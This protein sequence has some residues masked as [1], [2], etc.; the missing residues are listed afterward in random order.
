M[1]ASH[2]SQ[3][4]EHG[5]EPDI[6]KIPISRRRVVQ[7]LACSGAAL[8]L[9][10]R[11]MG[12]ATVLAADPAKK[13]GMIT[14]VTRAQNLET[15]VGELWNW[16]IPNDRFF[17]RSHFGPPPV[18][19]LKD[20]RVQVGG[21]VRRPLRLTLADLKGF[22]KATLPAVLQCSGN[23]RSFFSPSV[24]GT[25]WEKGA[26][27]N[28]WWTGVRLADVLEQAG[29]G[30]KAGHVQL[31]GADRPALPSVPLFVRSIPIDKAMHA[32]TLLAYE[33]NGEP[34]PL[35]HGAPV[36]L[37][38]PGWAGDAWVKWLAHLNV[39]EQ[40]AEGYYMQTAYRMPVKPIR[41]G[42]TVKP[43]ETTPVTDLLV[44]S[45]ITHPV[46]GSVLPVGD[47]LI[48]GVAFT[49]EGEVVRVEVS[50][51]AGGRWQEA[52]LVGERAAYAW[53]LWRYVWTGVQA[54]S[55]TIL[56]RATDSRGQVQPLVS[57]WNPG[58]FLWNA[59][60]RVRVRMQD[61]SVR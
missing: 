31:L 9:G 48:E 49:G 37:I 17:V 5:I 15:P 47:L 58:G 8:A 24:P 57:V 46:E 42:E 61:T 6:W 35:L 22:E 3:L 4:K 23:G 33:M 55:Y 11:G 36:R 7:Y 53:R 28:A 20:W 25:Q 2:S 51:D 40:E 18:E 50:L 39:Q 16:V 13:E 21:E 34:L 1:A 38:V 10:L 12:L 27:G 29:L 43:T 59:I 30:S 60:D 45:I 44:K 52:E 32:A 26:V 56:S 14:R 41:P 54:G 19:T